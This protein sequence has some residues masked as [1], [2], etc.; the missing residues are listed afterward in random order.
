MTEWQSI[1]TI[2]LDRPVIV[3]SLTGIECLART[4]NQRVRW[5]SKPAGRKPERVYCWR[6]DGTGWG[7]IS[8]VNW[9]EPPNG[10]DTAA[11]LEPA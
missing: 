1:E 9:R 5:I 8:A 4:K 7:D 6:I 2:P 3:R 11:T 10:P